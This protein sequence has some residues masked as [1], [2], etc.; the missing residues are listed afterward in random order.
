M[1]VFLFSLP[2]ESVCLMCFLS[3]F[4]FFSVY[5]SWPFCVI[6]LLQSLFLFCVCTAHVCY[7]L[8]S[9]LFFLYVS[10]S[11]FHSFYLPRLSNGS[12]AL[13]VHRFCTSCVSYGFV[14][15]VHKDVKGRSISSTDKIFQVSSEGSEPNSFNDL[16]MSQV[17]VRCFKASRCALA[18]CSRP[19]IVGS[20]T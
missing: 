2:T 17:K 15:E 3:L 7:F 18:K 13:S 9:C 10:A 1:T 11:S 4:F 16:F 5:Y 20:L 14:C 19:K 6:C 12:S 8:F